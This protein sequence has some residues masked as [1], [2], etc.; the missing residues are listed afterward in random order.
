MSGAIAVDAPE[1]LELGWG[2]LRHYM[3]LTVSERSVLM[4]YHLL[5]RAIVQL[6]DQYV[7]RDSG[8][9]RGIL[10]VY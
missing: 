1:N 2:I 8:S 9:G 10:G 5:D 6:S 3:T 7:M 4:N